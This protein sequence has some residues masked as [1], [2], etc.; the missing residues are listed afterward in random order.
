M[1]RV[2]IGD[3]LARVEAIITVAQRVLE[4][5]TRTESLGAQNVIQVQT[6]IAA[7]G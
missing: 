5:V 2:V 6:F 1:I 3:L 4:I 7:N